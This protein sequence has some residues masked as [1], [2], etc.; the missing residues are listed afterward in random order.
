MYTRHKVWKINAEA[1]VVDVWILDFSLVRRPISRV[2]DVHPV[3]L[4]TC[5]FRLI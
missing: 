2:V 5:F 3:A 4:I 1:M